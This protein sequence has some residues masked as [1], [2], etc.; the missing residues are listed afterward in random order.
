MP[1]VFPACSFE[2]CGL[3]IDLED[4]DLSGTD[5][6]HVHAYHLNEPV[7]KDTETYLVELYRRQHDEWKFKCI[8]GHRYKSAA[9]AVI[10]CSQ[11]EDIE[12]NAQEAIASNKD[13]V[14]SSFT[15][16]VKAK[17]AKTPR[18]VN[19]DL[20][21]A[22]DVDNVGTTEILSM[23]LL[24][25]QGMR[26]Q[27]AD[28]TDRI[29]DLLNQQKRIIEE[30]ADDVV[31]L[32]QRQKDLQRTIRNLDQYV[33]QQGRGPT[34]TTLPS[35]RTDGRRSRYLRFRIKLSDNSPRPRRR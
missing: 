11:C 13:L 28:K 32:L 34:E 29:E 22:E 6:K 24:E 3:G 5:L 20:D 9:S 25:M 35:Q 2:E 26:K 19:S 27:Q 18:N 21:S 16:T 33:R 23:F 12:R 15:I 31:Q 14:R 1:R 10:H 17:K 30:T 8:C 4:P 7:V